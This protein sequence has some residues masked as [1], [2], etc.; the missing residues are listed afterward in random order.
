MEEISL[1]ELFET[2]WK[3]KWIICIAI[4]ACI[5][6]GPLGAVILNPYEGQAKAVISLNFPGIEK[7]ENPDGSKFDINNVTSPVVIQKVID[8]LSLNTARNSI[9]RIRNSISVDPIIPHNV[10]TIV[11]NAIKT[12]KDYT[13]Y[14]SQYIITYNI[15]KSQKISKSLGRKILE[16]VIKYYEEYFNDLYTGRATMSNAIGTLDFEQYD[17]PEVAQILNSQIYILESFVSNK[18][19][20][21]GDFRSKNTG[22]SFADISQAINIL[23]NIDIN[24]MSSMISTVNLTKEKDKLI[25]SYEYRIK[26]LEL[27]KAKKESESIVARNMAESYKREQ[28]V[29]LIPGV[30]S[31]ELN[32]ES[33]KTYYED[34][35]KK[36]TEAGVVAQNIQHDIQY[37]R[38]EIEK[39]MND[40][41]PAEIKEST[42]AYVDEMLPEIKAKFENLIQITN[43]TVMEYY[44]FKYGKSINNISGVS[45]NTTL[46]IKMV[47]AVSLVL[48]LMLGVLIVFFKEFWARTGSDVALPV[49]FNKE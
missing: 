22:L 49:N 30:G 3:G 6:I 29:L 2:V 4:I 47:A 40:S 15:P 13:Y 10:V 27:E 43:E 25:A 20:E 42:K 28:N 33:Q 39:M 9:E 23:K 12:G 14:P 26:M 48:G 17:Y 7:G 24:K 1:R 46:N 37:Y 35:M 16:L 11:E 32:L 34:L 19:S 44:E 5:I 8:E 38:N 41:V 18:A 21:A 31:E 45:V 36:A